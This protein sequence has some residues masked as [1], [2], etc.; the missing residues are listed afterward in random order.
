[1]D[2]VSGI[3]RIIQTLGKRLS[4]R[5]TTSKTTGQTRT[6]YSNRKVGRSK[7]E[8]KAE[9]QR[10]IANALTRISPE[11]ERKSATVF[12]ESVLAWKLGDEVLN[13]PDFSD[14]SKAVIETLAQDPQEWQV[15]QEYLRSLREAS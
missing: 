10:Q 9:V 13:D 6:T 2:P 4:E 5:E 8:S 14:I 12:V 3:N 7:T 15:L 11:D 1:M